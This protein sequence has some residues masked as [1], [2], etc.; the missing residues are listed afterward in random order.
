LLLLAV[1][2]G[3]RWRSGAPPLVQG[4][5]AYQNAQ[6]GFRF[7]VPAGWRQHTRSEGPAA[8]APAERT[9]VKYKGGAAG[10]NPPALRVSVADVPAARP[11]TEVLRE[12]AK[13]PEQR[14]WAEPSAP[15]EEQVNG[16][17]AARS[18]ARANWGREKMLRETVAVRRGG[19]VYFFEGT[20]PA[21][22]AA[23]RALVAQAVQSAAWE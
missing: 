3:C 5:A 15:R 20:F 19:R 23:S 6:E 4:E 22:D 17:P 8:P 9:L 11:L 13:S 2:P 10:K 7:S 12:R 14:E 16:L 21:A 1:L 18:V